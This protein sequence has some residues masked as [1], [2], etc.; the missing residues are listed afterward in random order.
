MVALDDGTN[1]QFA[2]G[3]DGPGFVVAHAAPLDQITSKKGGPYSHGLI[4][5]RGQ[6]GLLSV[7]DD[8]TTL[9]L[10]VSGRDRSGALIPGK[11][12]A[13]VC[14]GTGGC[15]AAPSPLTTQ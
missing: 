12:L 13:L 15:E 5:K 1:S 11:R 9:Q 6:F 10:E 4:R 3:A 8:G 14:R 7:R 2:P